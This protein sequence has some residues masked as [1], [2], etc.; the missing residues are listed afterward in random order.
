VFGNR[1]LGHL[2]R[3]TVAVLLLLQAEG[4][5]AEPVPAEHTVSEDIDIKLITF[6]TAPYVFPKNAKEPGLAVR[7]LKAL[8]RRAGLSFNITV[9]PP[10]RAI[11][12]SL[13][14]PG[15][16]VFPIE[17]SQEREV[18][19]S[20][21]SPILISHQG[22]FKHPQTTSNTLR[23]LSD[24][25]DLTIGSYLGSGIGDYLSS[26]EFDVDFAASERSNIHKLMARRIDLWA[27]D[28]LTASYIAAQTG[29]PLGKSEL[30]FF[31]T[32]RAMG[33]HRSVP[34]HI[35]VALNR[36]LTMMYQDGSFKK[37]RVDFEKNLSLSLDP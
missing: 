4:V 9:M 32:L 5:L 6:E 8:M 31:T 30:V 13:R 27:A 29:F 20:W 11:L 16:C 33:C 34:Q 18:Q 15:T 24:V 25:Q 17:R 7:Y 1:P 37:L 36:V 12:F 21:V 26:L 2:V 14:T 22:F 10:K 28:T 23:V 3:Q 19:F 35:I